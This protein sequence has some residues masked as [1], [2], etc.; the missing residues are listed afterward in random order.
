MPPTAET[1]AKTTEAT[2]AAAISA[3]RPCDFFWPARYPTHDT[4]ENRF[5]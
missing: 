3:V 5:H 1:S 4:N 2:I